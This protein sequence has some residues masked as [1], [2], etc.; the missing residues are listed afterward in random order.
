[1]QGPIT[2]F[3]GSSYAGDARILDLQPK[4]ERLISY[5]IDLGTEVEPVQADPVDRL[6]QVRV[7]KGVIHAT[8]KVRE[9]R[10]FNV[11]N[12]S[13]HD[14][15][16]IIE[17]PYRADFKL[18]SPEKPGERARDVYRFE[19]AV[20]TGKTAKL[21][22][23]EEHDV[24]EEIALSN[25]NNDQIRIFLSG[26]VASAKVKEALRKTGELKDRLS[27]TQRDLEQL[28]R[29]LQE[30]GKDQE[31]LRAN[32]KEMPPT[33]AAHKRYLDKFD[34]QETEIEQLQAKL[35]E[36]QATELQ[37]RKE[38]DAYLANLTIE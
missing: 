3:D 32:L 35:K 24:L 18:I 5:A 19:L 22:V 15:M 7:N 33:A 13:E 1:M 9:S 30:I 4:E 37:Q 38:L 14:R 2:V 25:S 26:Q 6:I 16:L 20:A 21:N 36:L 31:R 27:A 17:H 23:I 11:K 34:K 28:N 8:H 10:T 12:R 29:G